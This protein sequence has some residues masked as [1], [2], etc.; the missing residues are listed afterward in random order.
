MVR[1]K[2]ASGGLFRRH[3]EMGSFDFVRLAPYFA[4]DDNGEGEIAVMNELFQ[5]LAKA[6]RGEKVF[7]M[8]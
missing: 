1:R 3:T 8:E 2:N 7:L 4:Q 5:R 6:I